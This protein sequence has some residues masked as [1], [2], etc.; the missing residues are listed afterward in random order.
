MHEAWFSMCAITV[1]I[2][3]G[4]ALYFEFDSIGLMTA[5]PIKSWSKYYQESS[6]ELK[7]RYEEKMRLLGCRKDPYSR[8]ES[9][10]KMSNIVILSIE[11]VGQ[12]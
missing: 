2:L 8:F 9:K 12:K 3:S 7:T 1:A 10:G 5:L 4:F 11:P 6:V